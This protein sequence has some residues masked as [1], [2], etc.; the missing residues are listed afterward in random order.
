MSFVLHGLSVNSFMTIEEKQE[1][2][3]WYR[4]YFEQNESTILETAEAEIYA[5][6]VEQIERKTVLSIS[7]QPTL[8]ND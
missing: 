3:E 1:V 4:V 5:D 2:I 8:G 7:K 6:L